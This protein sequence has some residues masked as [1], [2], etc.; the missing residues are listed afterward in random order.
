MPNSC[1]ANC[2]KQL[3]TVLQQKLVC[4]GILTE[5]YIKRVYCETTYCMSY[6]SNDMKAMQNLVNSLCCSQLQQLIGTF[7][8][9]TR[10]QATDKKENIMLLDSYLS[11]V[12]T[13]LCN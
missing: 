6:L 8:W 4:H 12:D 9:C 13:L 10:L 2:G 7:T 11:A 1:V 3:N 5:L